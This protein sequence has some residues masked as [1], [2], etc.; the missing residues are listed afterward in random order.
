MRPA[1]YQVRKSDRLFVLLL[2]LLKVVIVVVVVV[3]VA[4]EDQPLKLFES[5][6]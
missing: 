1:A 6:T 2:L 4:A 3:V 5:L